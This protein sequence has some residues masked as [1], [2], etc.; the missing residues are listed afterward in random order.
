MILLHLLL[1]VSSLFSHPENFFF[2]LSQV[3]RFFGLAICSL[4]E[5]NE[6]LNKEFFSMSEDAKGQRLS[7]GQTSMTTRGEFYNIWVDFLP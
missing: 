2:G 5:V 3:P 1:V 4:Y 7:L 6:R